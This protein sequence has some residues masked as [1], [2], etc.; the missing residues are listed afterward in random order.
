MIRESTF[1]QFLKKIQVLLISVFAF[2]GCQRTISWDFSAKGTLKDAAGICFPSTISG[3][4]YNGIT[5]GIDT[6]FIQVKVNVTS[7]GTYIISTDVQNGLQFFDSGTFNNTGIQLIKLKP[8]GK[9]ATP[10]A[11]NFA[12]RFDTSVCS[13][14]LDVKDSSSFNKDL[15]MWK[16]TDIKNGITYQG[17][18]NATYLLATPANNLLSLRKETTD[19][20]DTTFQIGIAFQGA[21]GPGIYKTDTLNNF[22]LSTKGRCINCAWGVIF[23]LKGAITTIVIKSYDPVTK[24]IKGT[25]SGTTIDWNNSVATIKDGEFTAVIK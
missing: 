13:V 1:K 18:I 8:V 25:F 10:G 24:I 4:F 19:P 12:I 11:T 17:I 6:A 2:A 9:P 22:A 14:T 3:T 21:L 15:N 23:K 7:P 16:Y 20:N 5:P